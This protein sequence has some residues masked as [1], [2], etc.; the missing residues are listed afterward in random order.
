MLRHSI[1]LGG[2]SGDSHSVGLHI[3]RQALTARGFDVLYIGTQN[4]IET[5][6][7]YA[8]SV[9]VIM[10]SCLDG[11]ARS[12]LKSFPELRLRYSGQNQPVWFLGGNPVVE[13]VIGGERLFLSMG[14]HR[15][16]L[17]FVNIEVVLDAVERAVNGAE[18]M[19]IPQA[20][21]E[22]AGQRRPV[23]PSWLSDEKMSEVDLMAERRQV[24]Q[25]WKTG[26]GA[27]D[28][29]DN[30]AFLRQMPNWT[31]LQTKVNAGDAA[32][33]I[34][35]RVGVPGE[36]K[37]L[38]LMQAYK[39][40]GA[41]VLS[42]QVDSYTR[43][44]NYPFAEEAMRE[45][46]RYGYSTMNGFPVVN[47]GVEPLRRIAVTIKL[48][49][50][51]RHSTRDPRLLC[52]ISLAGGVTAYEGGSICYNLPYYR[53]YPLAD[54]I[55]AWRYVDHLVGLYAEKYGIVVDREF[56][57]TLTTTLIPPCLAIGTGIIEAVLA[58]QQG[59]QAVSI[60]WA[61][62][63]CR[64]QDIAAIR[65]IE[66]LAREVLD[67]FGFRHVPVSSVYH[68][69]MAAF[70]GVATQSEELIYQ[71]SVTAALS[72]ATRMMTKTVVEAIKIPSMADNIAGLVTSQRGID[73][74]AQAFVNEPAVQAEMELIR[75]ETL[76]IVDG[77]IVLGKGNLAAGVVEGFRAGLLDIPFA[78][79][80]H[81]RGEAMCA[82]G[83]DKA[84]RFLNCGQLPLDTETRQFHAEAM[85]ERQRKEMLRE[86]QGYMLIERDAMQVAAGQFEHWPLAE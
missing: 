17:G 78:P 40:V 15:V 72:K 1:L 76:A 46:A 49:L 84:I 71:S 19:V 52:E 83:P 55:T 58:A 69:Y 51:T 66:P 16:F 74:A 57:G 62:Q 28:L 77:V 8:P 59:V 56:F 29:E 22:R 30:A 34:Q 42:Y 67:N 32:I 20:V 86:D 5:F 81:N 75:R 64:F 31:A 38:A 10:V 27:R 53:D 6:W 33:L 7:A 60:G 44:N 82:R 26:V 70:P 85:Q 14:F 68:Q 36:K 9:N 41:R 21:R 73:A 23:V 48:P 50:Q 13:D 37:Q 4:P 3:L 80:I 43:N 79:S 2:L 45:S 61:E 35:P 18:I 54:S 11:H 39:A 47:H 24:L 25:H 65:S 12:Y 63:G